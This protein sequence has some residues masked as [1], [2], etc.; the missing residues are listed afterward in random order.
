MMSNC[1][2]LFCAVCILYASHLSPK[3]TVIQFLAV[4]ADQPSECTAI[5]K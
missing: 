2:N 3:F 1:R 5:T 4:S